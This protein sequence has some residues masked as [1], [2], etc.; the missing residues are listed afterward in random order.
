MAGAPWDAPPLLSALQQ[1]Q[2]AG[3]EEEEGSRQE[4]GSDLAH[5]RVLT[6]PLAVPWR[7]PHASSLGARGCTGVLRRIPGAGAVPKKTGT[8][9][10]APHGLG[11]AASGPGCGRE[12]RSAPDSPVLPFWPPGAGLGRRGRRSPAPKAPAEGS[13][14]GAGAAGGEGSREIQGFL[15]GSSACS[16]GWRAG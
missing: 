1:P 12:K 9:C 16:E 4:E 5:P 8:R 11:R 15:P 6:H 13:R 10:R 2:R 3:E 7:I 14:G